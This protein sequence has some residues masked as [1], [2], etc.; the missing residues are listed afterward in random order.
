MRIK[1]IIIAII[2]LSLAGYGGLKLYMWKKVKNEVEQIF[3]AFGSGM[4]AAFGLKVVADYK[5][6]STSVF[7]PVGIKGISIKIPEFGEEI[8]VSEIR[9]LERD[10]N[11]DIEKGNLPLRMHVLI[12]GLKMD[13]SLYDKLGEN[14]GKIQRQHN[15]KED[16]TALVSR[17]GYREIVRRSSDLRSLGYRD[18]DMDLEFDMTINAESNEASIYFRQDTKNLGNYKIRLKVVGVSDKLNSI[19]LGVRIK[20]AKLEFVD[21]SYM[22]RFIKMYADENNMSLST[23]RKRLINNIKQD[24]AQKEINLSDDTINNILAFV[25]KPDKIVFTIHPSRPVAVESLKHYKAGDV[26]GL[27]N[28]QAHLK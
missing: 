13:I 2:M 14:T 12:S 6:I 10:L 26:P 16:P 3:N 27:L 21:D 24:I 22:N 5:Q 18:I 4:T 8:T 1:N 28:L 25:N 15:L 7:G 17:L 23:Y 9:L 19:V 20:E 11:F